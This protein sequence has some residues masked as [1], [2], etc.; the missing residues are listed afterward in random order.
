MDW[1]LCAICQE[2]TGEKL[3]CPLL[4]HA[5]SHKSIYHEFLARLQKFRDLGETDLKINN[6]DPHVWSEKNASWHASCR[7]KFSADKLQKAEER[8]KTSK[9]APRKSSRQSSQF[10]KLLCIFCQTEKK[11][12]DLHRCSTL[13]MDKRLREM[14]HHM[15][16][17]RLIGILAEGDAIAL[18][19]LYHRDCYTLYSRR[20]TDD[21][22]PRQPNQT[23][24]IMSLEEL[25]SEIA[26]Q[27]E[28]GTTVF[29]M[30]E[31]VDRYQS[32]LDD[33]APSVNPTR[34][35]N[36][37][38]EKFPD[39]EE[40]HGSR[41]RVYLIASMKM[42][43]LISDSIEKDQESILVRAAAICRRAVASTESYTFANNFKE[44]SDRLIPKQLRQLV[45]LLIL[46]PKSESADAKKVRSE[47]TITELLMFNMKNIAYKKTMEM[48]LPLY[49]GIWLHSQTRSKKL[50]K[51]LNEMGISVSYDRVIK[52]E[53]TMADRVI[54][55]SQTDQV[56]CP[57]NLRSN[58]F[59]VAALDNL[60]HNPSS[61]T[62]T[63]SFHGSA[64]SVFQ[65]P[66]K[67]NNGIARGNNAVQRV[68]PE[69]KTCLPE[70]YTSVP[71]LKKS[72]VTSVPQS[73]NK[74]NVS[75]LWKDGEIIRNEQLKEMKWI[76]HVKNHIKEESPTQAGVKFMW[77]AYHASQEDPNNQ[78]ALPV[79][80]SM[81][82]IFH[83]TSTDPQMVKHGMGLIQKITQHL[84]PG[85]IPILTVDQPLYAV[86][87]KIQW[88][89]PNE[90]GEDKFVL[91]MGGLHIEMA[92]WKALGDLLSGSGWP[93]VVAES[94]IATTGTATSFIRAS[95]PMKTRYA[96]QVT[97]VVLNILL[98][99]MY[100]MTNTDQSIDVWMECASK[101]NPTFKYWSL[102]MKFE[103]LILLFVRAH[104]SRDFKLYL[105]TL[106][107]LIGLFF[108]MDHQNY[109]RW[110]SV[111]IED[112]ESLPENVRQE[113]EDNGNWTV[114]RTGRRFSSIA[115]DQA[116]EQNNKKVKGVGGIIGLTEEPKAL[117]R[118]VLIAPSLARV[119]E[120]YNEHSSESSD[121]SDV[122]PHHEEGESYQ[123]RYLLH[124]QNMLDILDQKGNPFQ[125][126]TQ[127]VNLNSEVCLGSSS[128]ENIQCLEQK[129]CD[130]YR[131]YR[132]DVLENYTHQ[133]QEPI[134]KNR[135]TVFKQTKKRKTA[136]EKNLIVR[137][138]ESSLF[139]KLFI[140]LHSRQ[141][142]MALFFAHESSLPPPAT[143][144][145]T[146]K[147]DLL[148]CILE[149]SEEE[150]VADI[151]TSEAPEIYDAVIIDGGALIHSLPPKPSCSSFDDY[152]SMLFVPRIR[153]EFLSCHRLDIIWDRYFPMSI[154]E[155][156]RDKRS[157]DKDG[158]TRQRVVGSAKVPHGPNKWSS[159]LTDSKNKEELFDFLTSEAI[160]PG[161]YPDSKDLYITSN[162][163][164]L[165]TGPGE[166]MTEL[167][168]HEEA[169]TRIIVHMMKALNNNNTIL[170]QTCDTDVVI[171]ILGK[172]QDI[173]SKNQHADIWI[174]FG[175]GKTSRTLHVNHLAET[176]G[177]DRCS[178]LMMFHAL[179]GCDTTSGLKSKGKRLWWTTLLKQTQVIG[180]LNKIAN[181][182][183]DE[184]DDTDQDLLE[185]FVCRLY[186][187]KSEI[188]D[189]NRLRLTMFSQKYQDLQRIP[190]TRDA[191]R[192]H[193]QRSLYQASIWAT[194]HIAWAPFPDPCS[195]G[196]R[197]ENNKLVP[198]WTTVGLASEVF[199]L[200]VKCTCK[201]SCKPPC[202]CK[203]EGLACTG[204]CKCKCDAPGH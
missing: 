113:F 201:R 104:R 22:S 18:D 26:E 173:L 3:N 183:F 52:T 49:I 1:S 14:S 135:I 115:T 96:H 155:T 19:I 141:G 147:A 160:R 127:L 81:L 98:Q 23:P 88:T 37:I 7:R 41:R 9:K 100:N 35:K 118:W 187:P 79:I 171:I 72:L 69:Q 111:H 57:E 186:D 39:F 94:G 64:I 99:D 184:L 36:E 108:S 78:N 168:N 134:K 136:A 17:E 61:R 145:M 125:D 40:Q 8:F 175:R 137:K 119:I 191:W 182:P 167:S 129:G 177:L 60:D 77:S 181:G 138:D 32:K 103:Q 162:E 133:I 82:P 46:G 124:V 45:H 74:A 42:R 197:E 31:L 170:V 71:P 176:I 203:K 107:S 102:I 25:V 75:K 12:K 51:H 121:T 34:L 192:L 43:E 83:E 58:L 189:V 161:L 185:M 10:N 33:D 152:S 95:D 159:F 97:V 105:D 91:M 157:A 132:H 117:E 116:H 5:S 65:H 92:L 38:L 144:T 151:V 190:P 4:S 131:N 21:V 67:T 16:D 11:G 142:D 180:L 156:T 174:A 158:G 195:Y 110:L 204:L 200:K 48:P 73:T 80:E 154:K 30:R 47:R 63:S 27:I 29:S 54:H 66:S 149:H 199:N 130:Q 164:V 106:K 89:F 166:E 70:N 55:Q 15:K 196:W 90:F 165:H 126:E 150:E 202:K 128:I 84:N 169:D 68:S 86:G 123:K 2:D 85:Q 153:Y 109:A 194:S 24:S 178:A 62:S 28:N 93:E 112:L 122:L 148:H 163:A 44:C 76:E 139:G 193:V 140:S 188:T 13:N 56:V 120:E 53:R 20:Y 6:E 59:T 198:V 50:I 172:F 143:K 114:N 101:R 87:K 146:N 179:S